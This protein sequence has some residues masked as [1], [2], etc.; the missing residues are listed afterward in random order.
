MLDTPAEE[1]L[2]HTASLL[3]GTL[4]SDISVGLHFVLSVTGI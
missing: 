2:K 3:Q 4:V 1:P